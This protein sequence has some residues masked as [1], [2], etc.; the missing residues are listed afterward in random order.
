MKGH[1]IALTSAI[2]MGIHHYLGQLGFQHRFVSIYFGYSAGFLF[3][4]LLN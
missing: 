2:F 3:I 4:A 1:Q